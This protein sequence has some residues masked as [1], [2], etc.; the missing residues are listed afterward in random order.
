LGRQ[1]L[2]IDSTSVVHGMKASI[3]CFLGAYSTTQVY[4]QPLPNNTFHES[5]LKH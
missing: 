1:E 2:D 4:D 3:L 5:V